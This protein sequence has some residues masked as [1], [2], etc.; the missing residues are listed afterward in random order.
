MSRWIPIL[1]SCFLIEYISNI[2]E[3]LRLYKELNEIESEEELAV[4]EQ[5]LTDRFGPLP[6]PAKSLLDIVKLK[7]MAARAGIE[8]IILRQGIMMAYFVS[9]PDSVFYRSEIFAKV[10][11]FFEFP[12]R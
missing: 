9:S 11:G 12:E 1:K 8:K 4:F 2:S 7:W 10:M 3:R 6:Q 5:S